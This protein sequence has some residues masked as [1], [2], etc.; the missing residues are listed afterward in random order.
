[1]N[2]F[3]FGGVR[4][5][6]ARIVLPQGGAELSGAWMSSLV[7]LKAGEVEEGGRWRGGRGGS[8][9]LK[10]SLRSPPLENV[11]TRGTFQRKVKTIRTLQFVLRC[12]VW[13]VN[14]W[15]SLKA[16]FRDCFISLIIHLGASWLGSDVLRFL[17]CPLQRAIGISSLAFFFFFCLIQR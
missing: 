7:G 13:N 12:L 17:S 15:R 11:K 10:D 5:R 6:A 3:Y 14:I 2:A 4:Y 1:M 9:E 16:F 8:K